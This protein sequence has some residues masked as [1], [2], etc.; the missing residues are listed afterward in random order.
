[1]RTFYGS[2]NDPRNLNI[3]I[4]HQYSAPVHLVLYMFTVYV[5]W[6]E[7]EKRNSLLMPAIMELRNTH[8][9]AVIALI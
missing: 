8:R 1:M 5:Y 3:G 2:F 4:S 6:G 9:V 7:S